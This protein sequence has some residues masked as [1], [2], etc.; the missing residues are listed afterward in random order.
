M[1][2]STTARDDETTRD[3]NDNNN[4]IQCNSKDD[5]LTFFGDKKDIIQ[6]SLGGL[7][8][9]QKGIQLNYK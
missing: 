9:G 6:F 5:K 1:T 4:I 7:T 8:N 2:L 3:G